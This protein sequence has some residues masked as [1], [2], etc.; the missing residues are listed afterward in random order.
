MIDERMSETEIIARLASSRLGK[1]L[2][3][4]EL[5]LLIKA[6]DVKRYEAGELVIEEEAVAPDMFVILRNS[7]VIEM[8]GNE[9]PVYVCT[10]G[11]GEIIGEAGLFINVKRTANVRAADGAVLMRLGRDAFLRVLK[12]HS[13]VGIKLMFMIIY[14]LLTR[15]R[16][17]NE[18]LAFERRGDAN[19]AEIDAM[20]AELIPAETI[21]MLS[22]LRN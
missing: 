15:L 20:I 6:C 10:L 12:D 5:S 9:S 18:E 21:E 22:G 8:E 19:Q 3:E 14:G 4:P 13:P 17:A 11:E 2:S 1:H 7:V 16:S